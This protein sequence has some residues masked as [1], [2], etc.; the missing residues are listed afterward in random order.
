MKY[1]TA[2]SRNIIFNVVS[3]TGLSICTV[4]YYIT[5]HNAAVGVTHPTDGHPVVFVDTPGFDDTVKSDLAILAFVN[6][7]VMQ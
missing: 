3:E 4:L 6:S 1:T 5:Q 2:D 7:M